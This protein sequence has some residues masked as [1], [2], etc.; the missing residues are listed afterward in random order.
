MILGLCF[1]FMIMALVFMVWVY[2]IGFRV[3]G[4]SLY[5]GFRVY[6]FG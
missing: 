5:I 3:Y 1:G 6:G 2:D 4:L